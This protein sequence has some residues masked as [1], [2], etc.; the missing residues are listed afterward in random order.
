VSPPDQPDPDEAWKA[1]AMTFAFVGLCFLGLAALMV[2][3]G[4]RPA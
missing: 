3:M 1:L 4:W 2:L